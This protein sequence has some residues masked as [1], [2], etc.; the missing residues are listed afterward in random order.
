MRIIRSGYFAAI[1]LAAS[2]WLVRAEEEEDE[3]DMPEEM[4]GMEGMDG[5][6][7]MEGEELG[8]DD[9]QEVMDEMDTDKD[10]KL[11]LTELL[12]E[13]EDDQ[14][15]AD[16]IKAQFPKNDLDGDGGLNLEE[17]SEF[18]KFFGE[19]AAEEEL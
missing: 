9:V 13:T 7:G 2:L 1:A 15:T 17:L 4:E 11:S 6:E 3:G 5:E 14:E 18:I 8:I 10:G 16:A 19:Q 12:T